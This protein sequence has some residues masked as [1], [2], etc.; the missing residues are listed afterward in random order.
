VYCQHSGMQLD[1]SASFCSRCGQSTREAAQ[2][3][4]RVAGAAAVAVVTPNPVQALGAQVHVLGI[5][6]AVYSVLRLILSGW[7][8][9]FSRGMMRMSI[10]TWPRNIDPFPFMQFVR[11]IFVFSG[12][13]SLITGILGI[14]AA[15]AL[16]RRD[17]SGRTIAIVAACFALISFPVGT[18]MGIYTL[19]V[20]LRQGASDTYDR[21]SARS[22]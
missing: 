17:R 4:P 19:V 12:I 22:T 18:A 3:T 20:L 5:L 6:L 9:L 2:T 8:V 15:V 13:V 14:C 16:L 1:D 10:R 7:L 11:G 21:L